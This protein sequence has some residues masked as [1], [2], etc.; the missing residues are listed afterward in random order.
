MARTLMTESRSRGQ[1]VASMAA[2]ETPAERG[3]LT[4]KVMGIARPVKEKG[5]GGGGG[6]GEGEAVVKAG[7]LQHRDG[8]LV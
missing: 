5:T 7:G 6:G 3:T 4:L 2:M 8:T 1:N